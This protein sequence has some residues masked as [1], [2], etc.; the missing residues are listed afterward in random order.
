[1]MMVFA[2]SIVSSDDE[3]DPQPTRTVSVAN[4]TSK[5]LII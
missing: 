1:M 2:V 5:R 4:A 3:D